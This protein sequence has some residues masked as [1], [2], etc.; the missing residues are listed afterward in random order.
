[1]KKNV[2]S[3][4]TGSLIV[5]NSL[6]NAQP[7]ITAAGINFVVG[8]QLN[9]V[10]AT[11]VNPGSQGANQTWDLSAMVSSF[12]TQ[13]VGVTASSTP[14]ASNFTGATIA[15]NQPAYGNYSYYKINSSAQ[16]YY[17]YENVN[18]FQAYSDPEDM[19]RFP[20]TYNDTYIDPWSVTFLVSGTTKYRKGTTTVTA[21][22]Y[23]T[24][25]TPAGSFTN[26]LRV[27]FVEDYIDSMN[28]SGSPAITNLHQEQYFW[29][30]EGIHFALAEIY[31]AS[32]NNG[33]P[34][35]SG[36]YLA[37]PATGV[38]DLSNM[39]SEYSLSPNP[40]SEQVKLNFTLTENK[41]V[42][43]N[44]FN[45][46]GQNIQLEQTENEMQGANTIELN[47]AT[48]PEGIYFAQILLD[49]NVAGTKRFVVSK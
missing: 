20:F 30:K 11:Y 3:L 22:G 13:N 29:Y 42:T 36:T 2:L 1:M 24:L 26:V 23:G 41:K 14:Y 49:G 32:V 40:T 46:L 31:S 15:L 38:N 12:T 21:D 10:N 47:V 45:A 37:N 19:I 34:I 7:I 48:L 39:I 18:G 44:V 25:I 35:L 4:I 16:Q 8:D 27:H 5:L 17:G 33:A 6:S 28:F 9:V 43:I